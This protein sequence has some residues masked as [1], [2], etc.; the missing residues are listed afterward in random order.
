MPYLILLLIL[1]LNV[2]LCYAE[3]DSSIPEDQKKQ[4]VQ[5]ASQEAVDTVWN[6]MLQNK[7]EEL[8]EVKKKLS[9][10]N[11]IIP[12]ETKKLNAQSEAIET[13][14]RSLMSISRMSQNNPLKLS[15]IRMRLIRLDD[16]LHDSIAPLSSIA[17]SL[18]DSAAELME[19]KNAS[20]FE[21]GAHSSELDAFL[22]D[23]DSIV[24]DIKTLS[25]RI[26]RIL[27]QAQR[28]D[29]HIEKTIGGLYNELPKLWEEYYL[30]REQ[31]LLGH[32]SLDTIRKNVI[33][34]QEAFMLRMTSEL[35][36]TV[37]GWK[38]VLGRFL[39][40]LVPLQILSICSRMWAN[41]QEEPIKSGWLQ[42]TINSFIWFSTGIAMHFAAWQPSGASYHVIA[43]AGTV[44]LSLGQMALAWDLYTFERKDLKS[45]SPFLPLFAPLVGGL[46]LLLFDLPP[47]MLSAGWLLIL[48]ISITHSVL[49]RKT[50]STPFPLVSH[51]VACHTIIL[52]ISGIM[53]CMGWGRL[54]ILM[55]MS[56]VAIAVCIQQ[57]IG[58]MKVINLF[59]D[60]LPKKGLLTLWFGFL[61]AIAMP[62]I[63]IA[64]TAATALWLLAYP[65]GEY[66]LDQVAGLNFNI[67][68]STVDFLQILFIFSAFYITRSVTRVGHSFIAELPNRSLKFDK[69]L[70]S[71]IQ[72]LL[73]YLI[74][75]LF[76]LYAL[77]ALGVGIENFAMVAGGLS[78]GIG[79]G[80]QNIINNFISGLLVIFGQ[81]LREGDVI[82][83]GSGKIGTVRRISI[84][85]TMV[86]T[87]DGALT[88]IPNAEFLSGRLTNWT[89]N[90]RSVRR[91]L[92]VG[93]AYG[94]D[95]ALVIDLLINAAKKHQRILMYPEPQVL[96]KDFGASSL[97]FSLLFWVKDISIALAITADLR[98]AIERSFTEHGIEMAF[99]QLDVHLKECDSVP[100]SLRGNAK[101][102]NSA[103][104]PENS[105]A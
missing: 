73:S 104:E 96:F 105:E 16:S 80:M 93:V 4:E 24:R 56:Y 62:I 11:Q 20:S 30:D 53:T 64:A 43:V 40:L 47:L 76:G 55:A 48:G 74:W 84:R 69:N 103:H 7:I 45:H 49:K 37:Q 22:R 42:L 14:Y 102:E 1:C 46:L 85:S 17:Q 59:I 10:I 6:L 63:L 90:G 2:N 25:G 3:N 36:L 71:P 87:A 77:N 54:S 26:D 86:E 94:S 18:K 83:L 32:I 61:L 70:V 52:V 68:E 35:P 75:G 82:E 19:L 31:D 15:V 89:R 99:P 88:F 12:Q 50:R 57:A 101:K 100:I 67:G 91:E 21:A 65:G 33:A 23:V 34:T 28:Q 72:T 9:A 51:I 58:L 39:I 60:C 5:I 13:E 41:K 81:I 29:Q 98:V 92:N 97:D 79:F 95:V 8:T 78:V 27:R 66:L 38:A 44:V